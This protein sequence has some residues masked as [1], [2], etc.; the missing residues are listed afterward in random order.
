MKKRSKI[1]FR[2][3]SSI[4]P[5]MQL[6]GSHWCTKGGCEATIQR[7]KGLAPSKERRCIHIWNKSNDC[8][9]RQVEFKSATVTKLTSIHTRSFF[10][11]PSAPLIQNCPNSI[12]QLGATTPCILLLLFS[13]IH[14]NTIPHGHESFFLT[15]AQWHRK[16]MQNQRWSWDV[17]WGKNKWNWVGVEL[18]YEL[19]VELGIFETPYCINLIYLCYVHT[20]KQTS[21]VCLLFLHYC[22]LW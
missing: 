12:P 5:A 19:K 3:I 16:V 22:F 10:S 4:L 1:F 11:N 15:P 13:Y 18:G 21:K 17:S 20:G 2:P 9:F 8:D 7:F 6:I 14:T